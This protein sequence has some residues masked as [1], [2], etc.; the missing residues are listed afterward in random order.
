M[1]TRDVG[2]IEGLQE[3]Q[4][5]LQHE[6]SLGC[7]AVKEKS[8]TEE[9]GEESF[10]SAISR[11]KKLRLGLRLVIG[12]VLLLAVLGCVA[13]SK[14]TLVALANKLRHVTVNQTKQEL[15]DRSTD[16]SRLYWQLVIIL[17]LPHCLTFVRSAVVGVIGKTRKAHPWPRRSA[18]IAGALSS[19][20]EVVAMSVF[21]FSVLC[22]LTPL[23]A[24]LSMQPVF[25]AQFVLDIYYTPSRCRP[26]WNHRNGHYENLDH[27]ERSLLDMS[28]EYR[29]G[30][31]LGV[32][33]FNQRI[34][35]CFG[36]ILD[37]KIV[38]IVAFFLQVVGTGAIIATLVLT[39]KPD[40]DHHIPVIALPLSLVTL[41]ALWSHRFQEFLLQAPQRNQRNPE[42]VCERDGAADSSA[43]YKANFL[44]SFYRIVL[45]P[46]LA[47]GVF[48][49]IH[50]NKDID[51]WAASTLHLLGTG[52]DLTLFVAHILTSFFGYVFAWTACLM[53]LRTIGFA[54][55]LLLSTPVALLTGL[56]VPYF[57]EFSREHFSKF[58]SLN[59]AVIGLWFVV[60]LGQVLGIAYYLCTK[61]NLILSQ[62][63]DMF[64]NPHYESVFLEQYLSLNRQVDKYSNN[65]QVTFDGHLSEPRTIFICST[66]YREN[67]REMRQMLKSI[68]RMSEWY[69]DQRKLNGKRKDD[70]VES[71]I[72]FDGAVN[73]GQLTQY[74]VQLLSLVSECL[75]V[76][77]RSGTRKETYYGQSMS[78]Q[79]GERKMT[80]TVHFKD[81]LKVKNKKRW[82]QVMYMNYVLN[83]RIPESQTSKR[84]LNKDHTYILTTD[85]DIDFTAE[86][87]MV[88]MDSLAS[89]KE[90]GA[91]CAR[92]HPKGSG[93]LYWYQIFD[94]AIGHWF[95]KPA[96]HLLGS[97]LCCPGCFSVFRCRAL[98]GVLQEYS[99][100]VQ[101][102]ADFLYKDMGE[103]R[104]L[105][106]L[107][108][109][110]GWRLDYCAIS[111][112]HTYCP[113]SFDEFYRQR[114]RWV[115]SII[116]N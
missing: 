58:N 79:V 101:G 97:V 73:G 67:V 71:H 31:E 19:V 51:P 23:L 65:M 37:N 100:E 42:T 77:I 69:A 49:L 16:I 17:V 29:T 4:N 84:P 34:R 70:T 33:K 102:A 82:S 83:H 85:A 3:K 63:S 114:R 61:N 57:E 86:S 99:S 6:K 40:L 32:H 75:G 91:V 108:I 104:W 11:N 74:A 36:A 2:G 111:E 45:Y 39:H 88:L 90:V 20:L 107:L 8:G 89:N 72:F 44:N 109:Q 112:N 46:V 64:L 1:A 95:T 25:A 30:P 27:A 53:T 105:C 93:V 62:D 106:T 22:Y 103:D 66:M 54:L 55:P 59:Y 68:N 43:R 98:E 26:R 12:F 47:Y 80:F 41:G 21:V 113:E 60:Y 87:A 110:R 56:I 48:R 9:F 7:Q 5:V 18:L 78:W 94:Y 50:S 13:G 10:A 115:P 81:N 35:D 96:E 76:E 116:A 52:S 15:K 24:L 28:D 92:T 38:K 14:L